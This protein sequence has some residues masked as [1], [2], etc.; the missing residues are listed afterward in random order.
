LLFR[1]HGSLSVTYY[2]QT[3]EDLIQFVQLQSGSPPTYQYQN[4][5]R[6]KN[7]GVE[8]EGVANVGLLHLKGQ[9]G[10]ARSLVEQL[11]PNYSGD[12]QVGD[13]TLI[14]PKH[15][16]GGSLMIYPVG[17]TTV[18]AGITYV[19]GWTAYDILAL[20]RCFG[21]TGPCQSSFRGYHTAYPGFVKL[22]A[23]I[24]QQFTRQVVAFV[25]VDNLNNNEAYE[26]QNSV[27]VMGRITTLGFRM[28]Y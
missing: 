10:Y 22:S 28:H 26:V 9:Y 11:G 16:A 25:S 21:G 6:V 12:L 3:A 18:T 4:V 23:T 2:N 14:S 8:V 24:S 15:T 7:T 17:G 1:E 20:E 13:Q 27:P 5:G 19:G